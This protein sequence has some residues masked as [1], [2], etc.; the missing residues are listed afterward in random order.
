MPAVRPGGPWCGPRRGPTNR[1]GVPSARSRSAKPAVRG[2]VGHPVGGAVDEQDR[3]AGELRGRLARRQP[4][5][6]AGDG[7]D[8]GVA[9]DPQRGPAA[10]RVAEQADRPAGEPLGQLVERPGRRRRPVTSGR[11]SSRGPGSGS[12]R[13]RCRRGTRRRSAGRREHPQ[14]GQARRRHLDLA[15]LLA[16]VQHQRDGARVARGAATVRCGVRG[17]AATVTSGG[18]YGSASCRSGRCV[19]QT[20]VRWKFWYERLAVGPRWPW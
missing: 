17:H 11:R 20:S 16:A 4:R 5:G 15:G 8:R 12:P 3:A 7:G 10:H 1:T 13:R 18:A 9:A 6:E 2:G 14:V 19:A